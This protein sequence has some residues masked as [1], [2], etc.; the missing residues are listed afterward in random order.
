MRE[1]VQERS[2]WV[3]GGSKEAEGRACR[4]TLSS[5]RC[6]LSLENGACVGSARSIILRLRDISSRAA[7]P[8]PYRGRKKAARPSILIHREK[9]TILRLIG[10]PEGFGG[11]LAN[12]PSSRPRSCSRPESIRRLAPGELL[13]VSPEKRRSR[14]LFP[15]HPSIHPPILPPSQHRNHASSAT[16]RV[17]R[18]T[19]PPSHWQGQPCP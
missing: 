17:S 14:T 10:W 18:M 2:A 5:V 9:R 3:R 1:N 12:S 16:R 11:V 8:I 7:D 15:P 13:P 4:G 19:V 6:E